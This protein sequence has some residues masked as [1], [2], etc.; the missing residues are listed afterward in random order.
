MTF[1]KG[2]YG[3]PNTAKLLKHYINHERIKYTTGS[4]QL[5]DL[6]DNEPIFVT[7]RGTG[8]KREAWFYYWNKAMKYNSLKLN[9]HNARHWFV[10]TRMKMIYE[11]AKDESEFHRYKEQ[12]IVYM[13]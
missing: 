12:L 10:T 9:P 1:S 8:L 7:S 4:K 5:N 3:S 13:K 6:N 11:R 2:S